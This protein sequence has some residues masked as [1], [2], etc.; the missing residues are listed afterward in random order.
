[1]IRKYMYVEETSEVNMSKTFK[2]IDKTLILCTFVRY[3]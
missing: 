1:M 2:K 3:L